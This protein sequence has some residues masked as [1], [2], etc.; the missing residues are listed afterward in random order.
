MSFD[1]YEIAKHASTQLEQLGTKAKFWYRDDRGDRVLFKQGRPGTGENWAEKVSCEICNLLNLPH[2]QYELAKWNDK[3]GI[4]TPIFVPKNSR[5]VHGNELLGK[6]DGEYEETKRYR[7]GQ[8][9]IRRV[10]AV[11]N[12][13]EIKT[14]LE[15][16]KPAEITAATGVFVGY[17][18]LDALISNQDRHH[19]NWG[20]IIQI[21][22]GL[23]LAPTFDHASSLGRNEPDQTRLEMLQTKD[24]GRSVERYVGRAKSGFFQSTPPNK[25]LTT[26]DAFKEVAKLDIRAANYWLDQLKATQLINYID[27]INDIPGSLITDPARKF[28]LRMLEINRLRLLEVRENL[29]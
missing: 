5:L 18:M 6:L 4:I 22:E 29:K 7:S 16:N 8:H 17:L 19:E 14:P 20:I 10:V 15:W 27:I 9:T 23:S 28:A 12:S 11:L 3:D 21:T 24:I 13:K 1:V 2:A 26:L 25:S